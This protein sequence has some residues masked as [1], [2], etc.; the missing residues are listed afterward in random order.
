MLANWE[1]FDCIQA[2]LYSESDADLYREILRF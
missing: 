1:Y 2:C